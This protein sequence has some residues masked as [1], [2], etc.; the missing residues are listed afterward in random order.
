MQIHRQVEDG[1]AAPEHSVVYRVYTHP[2][3]QILLI[4]FICFCCPG[5]RFYSIDYF[6]PSNFPDVQCPNRPR[7]LRPSRPNS[8]RKRNRSP[9]LRNSRHS[10]LHRRPH[11]RPRRAPNLPF[12]GRVDIPAVRGESTLL[13][14]HPKRGVRDRLR[15]DSRCGRFI[16]LGLAGRNHDHLRA[17]VSER[18]SDCRVLDYIQ[19]R[20]RRRLTGEFRTELSFRE[21]DCF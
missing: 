6:T 5:V 11:L 3:F 16:P 21:R 19:S 17:R 8:R 2:W 14:P 13:Q 9:S 12:A 4:S 15:C 7:R 1:R 18:E 10:S 20:R